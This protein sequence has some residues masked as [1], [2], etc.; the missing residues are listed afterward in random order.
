MITANGVTLQFGKEP[1]FKDVTICFTDGNCYGLIGANGSGKSTFLKVLSG[2]I[3]PN[4]GTIDFPKGSRISV[5]EQDHFKFN[6]ETVLNTVIMGHKRLYEIMLE[7]DALYARNPFTDQ[8]GI[9][10]GELEEEFGELDGWG[11][12]ADAARLLS[13][14]GVSEN[15][16]EFKMA[17]VES[18][19][20][21]RVLL[22]RALVGNP[23]ILLL[24]EPTNHL[25]LETCMWLEDF[26]AGF[27][28]TA[29]VV[30]HDR[31]FLDNVCTH[32]AD[33]DYGKIQLY[34]GNYTFWSESSKLALKQRQ[35]RNKKIEEQRA[36]L[37]EFIARFSANLSK[38]RQATSRKKILEKLTIDQ[39][40]PS[41]RR[42]PFVEFK[43]EKDV[44]NDVLEI[45]NLTCSTD[46]TLM[47]GNFSMTLR[48]GER[49]AFLGR[50]DLART[51]LFQVLNGAQKADSGSFK[52]G[53]TVNVSYF[54]R[55]FGPFFDCDLDIINWLG[56]YS[57][58]KDES[59][60]RSFL[61]KM[62]FSGED[63]F[64]NVRVLSGGEKVRCMLSRMMLAGGNVLILDE[65]TNHLD[66]ESIT[67]LNEGL[68]RYTG[69]LMIASHDHQILQ[70]VANRIIEIAPGGVIDK[71]HHRLD[72]YLT[73]ETIKRQREALYG[74]AV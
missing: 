6:E 60:L 2:A 74:A 45:K 42:Y 44:G 65:P 34:P 24:D 35:E 56:Q 16:H 51:T 61:G 55:D 54:P 15:L 11:I 39:I 30:S 40:K 29:I 70:T 71:P 4:T 7:K 32:I 36:E 52:W 9:R 47:F 33:I 68:E 19:I 72:E 46:D 25:D 5:L 20:K 1:L 67:A 37:K 64:K 50:N 62:L 3:E 48:K 69:T 66:L 8:D 43:F 49:I 53:E 27:E 23:D 31:H 57:R 22:A 58:V 59:F 21:V 13:C 10:A 26:L 14:V 17:Q 73:N 63:V 38:S 18:S 41:S 12:E 28:N